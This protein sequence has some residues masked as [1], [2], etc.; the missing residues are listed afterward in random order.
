LVKKAKEKNVLIEIN[1]S[2][3]V[4]SRMGSEKTCTKIALLCKEYGVKIVVNS[5]AH[6]CFQIGDF[7]AAEKM[8][9]M[10]E[11]PEELIINKSKADFLAFL[12]DKG[13]HNL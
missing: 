12:K 1:N 9:K 13:K 6:S 5:D 4:R 8:L 3:S 2:S 7:S 10:I 11:M